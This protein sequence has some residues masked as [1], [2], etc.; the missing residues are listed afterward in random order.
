VLEA[1]QHLGLFPEPLTFGLGPF[2]LL[3]KKNFILAQFK[4]SF[5]STPLRGK[6]AAAKTIGII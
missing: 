5:G 2:F 3:K 4:K 1:F 6:A